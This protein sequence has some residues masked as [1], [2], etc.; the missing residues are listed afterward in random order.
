[1]AKN[2]PRTLGINLLYPAFLG[3]FLYSVI[4]GYFQPN[5]YAPLLGS[6][7]TEPMLASLKIILLL[8][9]LA[10]Y[11]CD[12]INSSLFPEDR[13]GPRSLALD[14]ISI[15]SLVVAFHA[16]HLERGSKV[17]MEPLSLFTFIADPCSFS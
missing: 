7:E 15:L 17:Q 1:M 13:Y 2:I 5:Y 3:T 14:I 8:V 11:L 16:L 12:F 10:F 4:A 6:F 9:S